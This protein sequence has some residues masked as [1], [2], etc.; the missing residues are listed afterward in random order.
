MYRHHRGGN[1]CFRAGAE[2]IAFDVDTDIRVTKNVF[3]RVTANTVEVV[4]RSTPEKHLMPSTVRKLLQS[5]SSPLSVTPCFSTDESWLEFHHSEYAHMA[6]KTL[7]PL[8]SFEAML[9]Y[10]VRFTAPILVADTMF[11]QLVEL[12]ERI[13]GVNHI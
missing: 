6:L 1:A 10:D 11:T 2:L 12:A 13:P 9:V 7:R 8:N 4:W 5:M 3:M